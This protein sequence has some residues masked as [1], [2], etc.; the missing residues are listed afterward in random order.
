[1]VRALS[2]TMLTIMF[3]C[4]F[5]VPVTSFHLLVEP[6]DE[7]IRNR[8]EFIAQIQPNLMKSLWE[9]LAPRYEGFSQYTIELLMDLLRETPKYFHTVVQQSFQAPTWEDRFQALEILYSLF[10][11]LTVENLSP[12]RTGEEPYLLPF[13]HLSLVFFCLA[14]SE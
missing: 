6:S 1:M 10:S 2:P 13:S 7:M 11:Q 9:T 3:Q 8:E 14:A 12:F 4:P 5:L